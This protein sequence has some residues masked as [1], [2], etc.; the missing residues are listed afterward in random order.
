MNATKEKMKEN[1][2]AEMKNAG[3]QEEVRFSDDLYREHILDHF[4]NPRNFGELRDCTLRHKELNPLCG[5]EMEIMLKINGQQAQEKKL[6]DI[7]FQGQ[8]CAISMA[9]AS[10]LSEHVKGKSVEEIKNVQ[11]EEMLGLLGI[12]VGVVRMKCA[13]LALKTLQKVLEE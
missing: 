5:D 3:L 11:P 13:L 1:Q 7:S 9:A 4:K 10:L 8:G 2:E 6:A 12:Q